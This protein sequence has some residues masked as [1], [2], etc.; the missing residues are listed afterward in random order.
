MRF[1]VRWIISAATLLVITQIIPGITVAG[2]FAAFMAALFLGLANVLIRP[3]LILLTLPLNIVTLG[4]F[5][6]VINGA[7]FWLVARV[8]D[9]FAVANFGAAF[10]GALIMSIVSMATVSLLN[11]K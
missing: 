11:K 2:W 8:V 3:I 5:T 6:F 4:L 1:I 10:L 9:G 7:L